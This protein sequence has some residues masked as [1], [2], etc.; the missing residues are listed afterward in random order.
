ML[1]KY[2]K[3]GGIDL[4]FYFT[5]TGNSKYVADYISEKIKD[6]KVSIN[7]ILKY[8]KEVSFTSEKPFVIVAPIYAWRLPIVV[9][10]F[11]RR[12]S[13]YGSR[14]LYFIGTME[15]E[16][17]NCDKYCNKLCKAKGMEFM[18]FCGVPMPSNYVISDIMLDE[19]AI[20][21]KLEEAIPFMEKISNHILNSNKIYKADKTSASGIK[22]GIVNLLFHRFMVSS[23]DY[24]VSEECIGCKKCE[25]ICMM[26]N[27]S[28]KDG[29]PQFADQCTNCYA[30][31]HHCPK[32]AINIKGKTEG[33][34]RYVCPE[35]LAK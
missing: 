17:G 6:E 5:G 23:K 1:R 35:Y 9:E 28:L 21:K 26:N 7:E 34:G 19:A 2:K 18:G 24:V 16:T 20:E 27:I 4:V 30:C 33:H 32:Q 14:K 8:H 31:I 12:S 11:V 25:E 10:N 29:K 22:S 3:Q 13:F 15:S